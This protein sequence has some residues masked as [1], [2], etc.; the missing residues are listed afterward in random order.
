VEAA[1]AAL[2]GVLQGAA[3]PAEP[4][5]VRAEQVRAEREWGQVPTRE[6]VAALQAAPLVHRRARPIRTHLWPRALGPAA[7]EV[8]ADLELARPTLTQPD[9]ALD[10]PQLL[11]LPAIQQD[12]VRKQLSNRRASLRLVQQ[13]PHKLPPREQIKPAQGQTAAV[14]SAVTGRL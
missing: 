5:G 13:E 12:R 10:S 7:L 4:R 8:P 3:P 2:V 14:S 6:W 11:A 1:V 9:P